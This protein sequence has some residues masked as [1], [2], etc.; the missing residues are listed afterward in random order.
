M[1]KLVIGFIAGLLIGIVISNIP[2]IRY[3]LNGN[4]KV[5]IGDQVKLVNYI[6][7]H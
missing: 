4:G 7:N 5:D 3:D 6:V 1:K 2:V